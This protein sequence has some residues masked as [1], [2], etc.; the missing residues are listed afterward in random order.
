[1]RFIDGFLLAPSK[2]WTV[3]SS[4]IAKPAS[5]YVVIGLGEIESRMR[6]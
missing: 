4:G 1:V 3:D 6:I 5:G 2:P